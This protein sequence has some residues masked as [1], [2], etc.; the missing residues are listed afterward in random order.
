MA[1][2]ELLSGGCLSSGVAWLE[3][4]GMCDLEVVVSPLLN[5][6]GGLCSSLSA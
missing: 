2:L 1:K 3:L 6:V 4:L 5:V